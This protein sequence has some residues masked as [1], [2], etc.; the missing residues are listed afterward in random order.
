MRASFNV[1][2]KMPVKGARLKR[3]LREWATAFVER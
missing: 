1:A 3:D 2:I